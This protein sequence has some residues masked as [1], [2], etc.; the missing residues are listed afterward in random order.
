M[1][2]TAVR[3]FAVGADKSGWVGTESAMAN[4]QVKVMLCEIVNQR[5]DDFENILAA[6]LES[7]LRCM[8]E[9][10]RRSVMVGRR[11]ST[12]EQVDREI[13]NLRTDLDT[14]VHNDNSRV[15]SL[16][17]QVLEQGSKLTSVRADLDMHLSECQMLRKTTSVERLLLE[18]ESSIEAMEDS[19]ARDTGRIEKLEEFTAGVYL[20]SQS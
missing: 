17:M 14:H 18:H 3:H 11:D 1:Q 19:V 5:L 6:K 20:R 7:R 8:E 15:C 16:A 13:F 4:D 2:R 10:L 9:D 12:V